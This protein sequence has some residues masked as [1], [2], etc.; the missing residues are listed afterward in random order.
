MGGGD[1]GRSGSLKRGFGAGF[2][3]ESGGKNE[4]RKVK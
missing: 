3:W 1:R 4:Q 2:I